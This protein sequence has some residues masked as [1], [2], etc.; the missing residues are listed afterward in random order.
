MK[1][2]RSLILF[3]LLLISLP[4]AA[5]N[6]G[7][8]FAWLSDTHVGSTTSVEDLEA[9][10]HDIN[11]LT[12]IKFVIISGDVTE[13]GSDAQLT[14][15]KAILDSLTIPYYIIPGNHDTKWSE[16]G[17]T[18]F[19]R[20]WGDDH[21]VF[22]AEGFRF[23]GLHEGPIMKMGDGHWA[24]EDMRWLDSVLTAMPNP[25]QPVI[26]V[27][28]YPVDP[29]IDNW[30]ELIDRVKNYNT[31]VILCGHGHRNKAF[32]FE[33]IPGVMGR[34]NLRARD[35]VGGYNLV[36]L[37]PDEMVFR[38]RKPDG[39]TLAP[40]DSVQLGPRDYTSDTTHYARPDFSVN[41]KYPGVRT[42]W[43]YRSGFTMASSP[44]IWNQT[45]IIGD[46]SGKVVG[47]SL[48]D[49][50]VRWTLQTGG[51]VFST[52]DV[53]GGLAVFASC[54]GSI[55]CIRAETGTIVWKVQTAKPIVA[56]PKIESNVVYIGSS[57]GK[58]RALDLRDGTPRWSYDSLGGF[59]E[60]RPL[61]TD[62]LVIFGAWDTYLY[63]LDASTGAL[64]WKWQGDR[65]GVGYSPA[66]CWPVAAHGKVFVVAPDRR[67]TALD[68][69]TGK[70]IWRTA[71]FQ[72]RESIGI[73]EDREQVYVRTMRDS[74]YALS[75]SADV[76]SVVW[77]WD[78][79]FGYDINSAMLSEK[80]GVVFYGTKNGLILALKATTGEPIWEHKEG[81]TIVHTITPLTFRSILTADFD[82]YVRLLEYSGGEK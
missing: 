65:P 74:V 34:S 71:E 30:Y 63:A 49:G 41:E 47:L 3:F 2:I 48:S 5:Q 17:A 81:V 43:T 27:T 42:V 53:A 72:V 61:V 7:I 76:P 69:A 78:L 59:V 39:E 1:N 73:S 4:L 22:E 80:D 35:S 62:G 16:S 13:F 23:I 32:D 14:L 45:A 64:R 18:F 52:P 24:P 33:G 21:F 67:M 15:A 36:D 44:A 9:S 29:S 55:Y 57:E 20:L 56:C 12:G 51:P 77:G 10:V 38:V 54:D 46:R 58:F 19:P 68:L 75:T 70:E 11:T 50:S 8:R 79:G 66:A 31:Q 60:T 40:W 82:G 26:I 28:H 6:G 25:R 37:R